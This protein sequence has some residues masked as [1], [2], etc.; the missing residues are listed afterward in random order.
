[1]GRFPRNLVCSIGD[2]GPSGRGSGNRGRGRQYFQGPGQQRRSE[3]IA[4]ATGLTASQGGAGRGRGG[5]CDISAWLH[6]GAQSQPVHTP[7]HAPAWG[8]TTQDSGNQPY[9]PGEAMLTNDKVYSSDSNTEQDDENELDN[10]SNVKAI[11]VLLDIRRD[12]RKINTKFYKMKRCVK[13]LKKSNSE[14][15]KQNVELQQAV[16]ELNVQVGDLQKMVIQNADKNEKLEAHSR[17]NNLLI[18]S[19]DQERDRM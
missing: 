14:L 7:Q 11:H 12:V 5:Q 9:D 13:E 18:Y 19:I 16:G 4:S 8:Q 1:M 15:R 10:E 3:C 2:A 17:R 6:S